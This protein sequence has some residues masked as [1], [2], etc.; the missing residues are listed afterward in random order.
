MIGLGIILLLLFIAVERRAKETILPRLTYQRSNGLKWIYLTVA[1]LSAGVMVENFIPLFG[2][3][4]AGLNP[5]IA[6]FLGA[7]LSLAWVITQILVVAAR[8]QKNRRRAICLG[9]ILLTAGLLAYKSAADGQCRR[10]AGGRL[11]SGLG[12]GRNWRRSC[13]SAA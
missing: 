11:G 7:V 13:L 5:L 4:L 1:A 3:N 10:G 12:S 6:G 9:P 8:C 2:Q